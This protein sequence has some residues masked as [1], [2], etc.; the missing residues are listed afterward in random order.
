M[1]PKDSPLAASDQ[2][3]LFASASGDMAL[4]TLVGIEGSFSRRLG[5]Q[6]AIALDGSTVGSLSDGCLERQLATD[7]LAA[8]AAGEGPSVKRYGRGSPLIDF[9]LPCGGGLDIL[10]DPTPDRAKLRQVAERLTAR[11]EA[12]LDLPLPPGLNADLLR[13]RAYIPC[14][15]VLLF[16]EGPEF[17]AFAAL[18]TSLGAKVE[19]HAR[20]DSERGGLMLGQIP[21][22]LAADPWTAI[23]LLFH[24]HE[25]ERALLS[26]AVTAPAFFIGAQGGAGAREERREALRASGVTEDGIA[27]VRSPIG[28]ITSARN[29]EVLALSVLA[30][31]VDAYE[32][33]H[34]HK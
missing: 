22:D 24:D 7:A 12:S 21:P 3:A 15:R 20:A 18:A 5:A 4:C 17:T 33:L 2:V 14:L 31:I 1:V 29:P 10:I 26:W 6:I 25:W 16:G 32:K 19:S 8:R 11:H 27:R 30:E 9:R 23:L 28:L 13:Q 34:P